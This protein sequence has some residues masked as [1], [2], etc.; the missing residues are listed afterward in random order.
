[1]KYDVIL[2]IARKDAYFLHRT[3]DYVQRNLVEV[4]NIYI[5]TNINNFRIL[6]K[7]VN[8][9]SNVLMLDENA[10][11]EGL[12]YKNV[13]TILKRYGAER[14]TGWYFQQLLKLG[15][16]MTSYAKSNYLSWDADTIPLSPIKFEEEGKLC[17]DCKKE[18]HE[19]YFTSIQRLLGLPKIIE[20]SFIA[21]HMLFEKNIV[22]EMICKIENQNDVTGN[23]WWEKILAS[24]DYA[25]SLNSFSEFETYGT[26]AYSKNP[27][28]YKLRHLSTFRK[29]GLINGRFISDKMLDKLSFDLDTISFEL[30]DTPA[31]PLNIRCYIYR[32]WLKLI[33]K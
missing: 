13:H 5:I 1:M 16:A 31:F 17:F 11:I 19:P 2:P 22:E 28:R 7:V 32:L 24:C 25:H 8:S 20:E 18:Y 15:F 14:I 30:R 27:N 3:L 12:S 33:A 10:L 23:S 6:R 29:G 4:E 21:E 9:N 26:Y